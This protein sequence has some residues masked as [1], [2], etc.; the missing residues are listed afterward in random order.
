M[1]ERGEMPKCQ[2]YLSLCSNINVQL[3][4]T[5]PFDNFPIFFGPIYLHEKKKDHYLGRSRNSGIETQSL[6]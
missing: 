2:Q 1:R 6:T 3:L 4:F 5:L